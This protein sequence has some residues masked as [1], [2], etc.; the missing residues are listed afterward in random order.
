MQ[1]RK[2]VD[3]DAK[4]AQRAG[5]IAHLPPDHI[6]TAINGHV[7]R[8]G[9]QNRDRQRVA[10]RGGRRKGRLTRADHKACAFAHHIDNLGGGQA[11]RGLRRQSRLLRPGLCPLVRPSR[12]VPDIDKTGRVCTQ[13]LGQHLEKRP[14]L[15]AGDDHLTRLD[16]GCRNLCLRSAQIGVNG[17]RL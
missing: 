16:C 7:R 14:F 15:R 6:K 3:L 9:L 17:G 2:P 1:L 8:I 10:E 5:Q 11:Q 4:P 12:P 13:L